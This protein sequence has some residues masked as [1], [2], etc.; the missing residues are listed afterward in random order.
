MLPATARSNH[1]DLQIP[2][3]GMGIFTQGC[4]NQWHVDASLLGKQYGGVD[5]ADQCAGIPAALKPGCDFRFK[6][7]Q[8]A[9]NPGAT[10]ERVPCP[11][12]ITKISNCK[13][14]DD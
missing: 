2:A 8:N 5:S 7:F 4:P 11:D 6:W 10:F 13:R 1:F 12:A 3:S 14:A 9:D